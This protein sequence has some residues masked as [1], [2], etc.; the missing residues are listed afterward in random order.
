MS[1]KQNYDLSEKDCPVYENYVHAEVCAEI[2]RELAA[3]QAEVERLNNILENTRMS[4]ATIIEDR[5]I[6]DQELAASQAGVER[7][8][9]LLNR[10]IETAE[11]MQMAHACDFCECNLRYLR[12][13]I[14]ALTQQQNEKRKNQKLPTPCRN[15]NH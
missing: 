7:L 10:A 1:L 2:E 5:N 14:E 13:E 12:D 4:R 8:R 6:L 3:S 11:V 15:R 9:E